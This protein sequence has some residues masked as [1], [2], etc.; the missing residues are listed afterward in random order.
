METFDWPF[1]TIK[2]KYP[3]TTIRFQFGRSYLFAVPPASPDQRMFSLRF[4]TLIYLET[5]PGSGVLD[6][7][8]EPNLNL[9]RLEDFYNRH[10]MF[11]SFDFIHPAHGAMVCKFNMPLEVP[12]GI[13]GGF[14]SVEEVN[15]EFIEIP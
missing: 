7:T 10:K 11:Q 9:G 2:T 3:D 13:P 14:G 15:L 6:L 12:D 5:T 1:F 4:P 8:T